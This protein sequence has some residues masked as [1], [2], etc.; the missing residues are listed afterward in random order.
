MTLIYKTDI[1][2]YISLLD[3]YFSKEK[4]TIH[5]MGFFITGLP[6]K[7]ETSETIVQNLHCLVPQSMVFT[8]SSFVSNQL[9][10][11]LQDGHVKKS[12]HKFTR[13]TLKR[14]I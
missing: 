4:K 14:S 11:F 9:Y 6:T 5:K 1:I 3:G 10:Q 13:W 12:K 2:Q 7:D 8:I